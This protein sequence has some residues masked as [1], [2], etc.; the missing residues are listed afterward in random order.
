MVWNTF[1]KKLSP[2][3]NSNLMYSCPDFFFPQS[4][5]KF[6]RFQLNHGHDGLCLSNKM[7]LVSGKNKVSALI[8][9]VATEGVVELG[10][11]T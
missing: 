1:I 5:W 8:S 2:V 10:W 11:A 3:A 9:L 7:R 4:L 6:G